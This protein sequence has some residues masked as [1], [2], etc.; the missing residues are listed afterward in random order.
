MA[1]TTS[2]VQLP[3]CLFRFRCLLRCFARTPKQTNS[4]KIQAALLWARTAATDKHHPGHGRTSRSC[5][6][7]LQMV[8]NLGCDRNCSV[9]ALCLDSETSSY[10]KEEGVRDSAQGPEVGPVVRPPCFPSPATRLAFQSLCWRTVHASECCLTCLFLPSSDF[11]L[12]GRL[13]PR[14]IDCLLAC[15]LSLFA[16]RHMRLLVSVETIEYPK[17]LIAIC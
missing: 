8:G 4:Y 5:W 15:L 12:P 2:F 9:V 13:I 10:K 6:F 7:G 17:H 16:F 3:A 14:V 11:S 1:P